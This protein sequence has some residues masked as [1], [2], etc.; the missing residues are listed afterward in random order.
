MTNRW[1]FYQT[2]HYFDILFRCVNENGSKWC[3]IE[4]CFFA[5]S[6]PKLVPMQQIGETIKAFQQSIIFATECWLLQMGQ[7]HKMQGASKIVPNMLSIP[8]TH[9][10][11]AL[12]AV[13]AITIPVS[14]I[15][16]S[17]VDHP[18]SSLIAFVTSI[19]KLFDSNRSLLK[20]CFLNPPL[21]P[22]N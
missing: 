4:I 2:F 16:K 19:F 9:H 7:L 3:N 1:S 12:F 14:L 22:G 20:M 10:K 6:C 18:P 5:N 8:L 17:Q 13:F 15:C 21:C 11:D